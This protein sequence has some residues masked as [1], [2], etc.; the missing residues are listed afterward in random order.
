MAWAYI[1]VVAAFEL[2]L[3]R[4][5]RATGSD[6]VIAG[7]APYHF[8]E[9]EARLVQRYRFYFTYPV[10]ARGASSVLAAI[11]LTGLVLALWLTYRFAFL[12]AALI[13][14][15]LFA[16]ARFTRRL[17]PVMALRLAASRGEREALD[18]LS[19]HDPAWVKIRAANDPESK[20]G[21]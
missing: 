18:L 12:P 3:A 4:R 9:E 2:W 21:G 17:S 10:L 14:I 6:A 20:I 8:T 5:V 15:N 16:V 19:A 7:E 1:A 11:G 13:G